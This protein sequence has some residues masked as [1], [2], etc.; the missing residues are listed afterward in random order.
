MQRQV[1]NRLSYVRGHVEAVRKMVERGA[2]CPEIILQNLAVV[3]ALKRVNELILTEHLRTCA[4]RAMRG[5]NARA[6]NRV[7]RE[8]IEIVR[9]T[10]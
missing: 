1:M 3:Q 2:Y 8:I 7:E 10:C 6:R 5:G 4:R 9:N